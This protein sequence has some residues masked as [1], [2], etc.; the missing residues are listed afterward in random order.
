MP[1]GLKGTGMKTCLQHLLPRLF[2]APPAQSAT[3]A[4]GAL[5]NAPDQQAKTVPA[6][7]V[8]GPRRPLID[9]NGAIAG[10]EF[11]INKN[12]LDRLDHRA[13]PLGRG[14]HVAALLTSARL[15]AASGR[16]GLARVPVDW[17]AHTVA[18]EVSAGV[19]VGIEPAT[20]QHHEN[21]LLPAARQLV[22]QL[23]TCLLYTS[24]CV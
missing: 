2:G 23:R 18:V 7:Q 13:D 4:A 10:F 9:S 24:R 19:W 1:L 12:I 15:L 8:T 5:A 11:H 14:A 20:E 22:Q 17:L 6:A 3:E 16:T 21:L